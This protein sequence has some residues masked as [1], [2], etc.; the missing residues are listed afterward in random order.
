MGV[1]LGQLGVIPADLMAETVPSTAIRAQFGDKEICWRVNLCVL[2]DGEITGHYT[3]GYAEHKIYGKIVSHQSC[4]IRLGGWLIGDTLKLSEQENHISGRLGGKYRGYA[5]S[6]DILESDQVEGWMGPWRKRQSIMVSYNDVEP[7]LAF[8]VG[9]IA[10]H[11]TYYLYHN[12]DLS[13]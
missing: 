5:V 7:L 11:C 3:G 6:G 4:Q 1:V 2:P 13:W 10:C 9:C 12:P 8:I